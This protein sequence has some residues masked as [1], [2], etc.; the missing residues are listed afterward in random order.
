MKIF[1]LFMFGWLFLI[2]EISTNK[3]SDDV[4]IKE[5]ISNLELEY[6][7]EVVHLSFFSIDELRPYS[8]LQNESTVSIYTNSW[9]SPTEYLKSLSL[10]ERKSLDSRIFSYVEDFDT[11]HLLQ[12]YNKIKNYL[13]TYTVFEKLLVD[14]DVTKKLKIFQTLRQMDKT[15]SAFDHISTLGEFNTEDLKSNEL[16]QAK[17]K[18]Y[19]KIADLD[20][21]SRLLYY[22]EFFK[23][24]SSI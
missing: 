16:N 17:V 14:S 2:P 15:R 7:Q 18:A 5:F 10:D 11:T 6:G 22:S 23:S 8:I 20:E 9:V 1:A 4:D 13:Y 19:N 12:I 3:T 21:Q 24:I